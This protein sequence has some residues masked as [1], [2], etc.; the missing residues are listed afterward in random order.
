MPRIKV[1]GAEFNFN[2]VR[3]SYNRRAQQFKN[4]IITTLRKIN[5]TE[6]DV[7]IKLEANCRIKAPGVAEWYYEGYRLYLSYNL[8]NK[9]AENLYVVSKVIEFYVKAFVNNEIT[10]DDFTRKFSEEDDIEKQRKE[11]RKLLGVDENC[12]D[13]DEISRKYKVLAKKFHPDMPEGN[14]ETFKKINNAHKM[15]KRELE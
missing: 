1:K 10:L 3:D 13:M 8:Q 7:E 12:V 11:S 2:P 15:L 9:Y 6:D 14:L 5:L 4:D